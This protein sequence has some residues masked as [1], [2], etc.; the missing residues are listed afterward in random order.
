MPPI[1]FIGI[2]LSGALTG[3]MVG[4]S[5][6]PVVGAALPAI[7]TGIAGAVAIFFRNPLD[8][9]ISEVLSS[10]NE[11]EHKPVGKPGGLA[12]GPVEVRRAVI[13]GELKSLKERRKKLPVL[14]GW[15][16]TL[17]VCSYF[18]GFLGG[19]KW[20]MESSKVTELPVSPVLASALDRAHSIREVWMQIY[21]YRNFVN[22]GIKE[23]AIAKIL[24]LPEE[25][26]VL[27]QPNSS[28]SPNPEPTPYQLPWMNGWPYG[29]PG[30]PG[31]TD[32]GLPV[33]PQ[34]LPISPR[35]WEAIKPRPMPVFPDK[36]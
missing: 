28:P 14:L 16:L 13:L 17:F 2:C 20:R 5:S 24:T 34:P 32:K 11:E 8:T 31:P 3:L 21:Y 30:A 35:E 19:A 1:L 33:L 23:A 12:H 26:P 18:G 22:Q 6:S 29:W 7:V 36:S 15:L 10:W 4:L 25:L 9:Q 27:N